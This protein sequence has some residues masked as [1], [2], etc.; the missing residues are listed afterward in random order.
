MTRE[1]I[2]VGELDQHA[3]HNAA[4]GKTPVFIAVDGVAKAV[5]AIADPLKAEA[6]SMV[7]ALRQRGIQVAMITG[8]SRKTAA[9]IARRAGIEGGMGGLSDQPQ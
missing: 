6:A 8:D 1:N 5:L 9:A 7:Q 3:E 4:D 2:E